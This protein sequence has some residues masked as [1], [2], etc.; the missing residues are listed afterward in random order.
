MN[1][2]FKFKSVL[3]FGAMALSSLLTNAVRA[4]ITVTVDPNDAWQGFMNVSEIDR[5]GPV[6]VP[7]AFVFGSPW[8]FEDLT[9]SFGAGGTLTLGV[10]TIGDPDPFWYVGGGGPGALGNKWMDA[11]GFVQVT[12]DP[13]FSG[14]NVT[15]TG[16]VQS[17]TFTE[18]HTASA[19]IRD[20]APDFSSFQ[21]ASMALTP[22]VFSVTL[23]TL[24]DPGR[25]IQFGFNVAGEN[26]WITDAASFGTAQI[27]AIPEPSSLLLLAPL[28]F[29]ATIIR[30]R[31]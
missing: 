17:N 7:G 26:V 31:G 3:L 24:A 19:F 20:F 30:R 8:G 2:Y 16:I 4:D 18:N 12:N 9:A 22:G 14:V 11:N 10:N 6:P 23:P 25:H 29:A 13:S 15:F 27:T 28:A 21:E 1:R 5:S